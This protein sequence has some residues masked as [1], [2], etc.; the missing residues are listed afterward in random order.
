MAI[1]LQLQSASAA[2]AAADAPVAGGTLIASIFP[3]PTSMINVIHNI[4]SNSVV[5]ANVFDG[6][7]GYDRNGEPQPA[8]ATS[9]ALSDGGRTITFQLRKGVKWHD[10]TDF[11]SRDMRYSA[12]EAWKKR[13]SRGRSTFAGLLDVETPDPLTAVFKLNAPSPVVL[14]SLAAAESIVLPAHLYEGTDIA[15]NPYNNKPIGTGPFRFVAWKRG[16]V[17]ELAR[18]PSYWDAGKPYLN[19]VFFRYI[20]DEGARAAALET[21]EVQYAPYDPVPY[22]DVAR[23]RKL[24][25]LRIE[26]SGYD[27]KSQI[28]VLE[29]NLRNPI[30]QNLLVRQ[31]IAHAIDKQGLIK[32]VVNGFGKV[33]TGPVPSVAKYYTN[34]VARYDADIAK[35]NALLDEAGYP[36]GKD[37]M[38]F[39]LRI[40]QQAFP[41]YLNSSEYIRQNL[42]RIGI[43]VRVI[44]RDNPAFIKAIYGEYDFDLNNLIISAFIEPQMGIVRLLSSQMAAKGVPYVIASGYQNP[45]VD[46]LIAGVKE[47][48]DPVK[49]KQAFVRVQQIAQKDLP[50]VPLYEL[51]HFTVFNQRVHGVNGNP[52]GADTSLKDVWLSK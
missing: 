10:G 34:D 21:G 42:A 38:R 19:K 3:E 22:A 20:A 35:A 28:Q 48:L 37:G 16:E 50:F 23:V 43:D 1:V 6:L 45:E 52:D 25:Q 12:L 32:T 24:P 33:A 8:L 26:T 18:N 4:Y 15:Q 40:D 5:A 44:A 39:A 49:R 29:F 27:W 41:V 36:R 14:Q 51:V 30:L 7:L 46:K 47:E 11:T 9:W 2:Q 13:H 31:A 17:V